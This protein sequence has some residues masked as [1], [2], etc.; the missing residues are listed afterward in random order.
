MPLEASSTGNPARRGQSHA[1]VDRVVRRVAPCRYAASRGNRPCRQRLAAAAA[2]RRRADRRHL[3]G[4]RAYKR[5]PMTGMRSDAKAMEE[6]DDGRAHLGTVGRRIAGAV[7]R[8]ER[9]GGRNRTGEAGL[10]ARRHTVG[11]DAHAVSAGKAGPAERMPQVA[12]ATASFSRFDRIAGPDTLVRRK[13]GCSAMATVTRADLTDAVH[14]EIGL[15]RRDAAVT[16]TAGRHHPPPLADWLPQER[17]RDAALAERGRGSATRSARPAIWPHVPAIEHRSKPAKCAAIRD[18]IERIVLTPS[19]KWAA[20]TLEAVP[21]RARRVV[22]FRAS[23]VLRKRIA[24]SLPAADMA[25]G[26]DGGADTEGDRP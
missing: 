13:E 11:R 2:G 4:V 5:S 16:H 6:H 1:E 10:A 23:K 21:V 26:H 19:E 3:A 9:T 18:L 15:P 20:R 25:G 17:D 12:S 24:E 7:P 22:V 14:W 8:M